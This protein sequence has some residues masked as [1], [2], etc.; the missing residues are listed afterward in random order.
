MVPRR[1]YIA[2]PMTGIP[3]FNIPRF[4]EVADW[5]RDLGMDPVSPAELDSDNDRARAMAS[6]DGH[7]VHYE[8][9]KTWGDFLARDIKLIV[10]TPDID[11]IMVLEGWEGS[12]GARFETFTGSKMRAVSLPIITLDFDLVPNLAL[13][14]AWMKDESICLWQAAYR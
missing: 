8:N 13:Y 12:R 5:L 1:P 6:P 2:G 11:A 3:R 10:D 4:D 9:G 14:R 7:V